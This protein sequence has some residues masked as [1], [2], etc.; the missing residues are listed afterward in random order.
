VETGS[1]L[2][3]YVKADGR[4]SLEAFWKT[5]DRG[6]GVA[7]LRIFLPAFQQLLGRLWEVADPGRDCTAAMATV[8][9][10]NRVSFHSSLLKRRPSPAFERPVYSANGWLADDDD[11][12][13]QQRA[14]GVFHGE[15]RAQQWRAIQAHTT[16]NS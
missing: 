7:V 6:I 14:A 16:G 3:G 4:T 9:E 5:P 2:F 10:S 8:V 15:R 13:S 1:C 11:D 12:T